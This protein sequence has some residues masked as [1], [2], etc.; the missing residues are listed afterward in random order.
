M[1]QIPRSHLF[2]NRSIQR[3]ADLVAK[4][5]D[6][7]AKHEQDLKILRNKLVLDPRDSGDYNIFICTSKTFFISRPTNTLCTSSTSNTSLISPSW[8]INYH[9]L[10]FQGNLWHHFHQQNGS[11]HNWISKKQI[12]RSNSFK[13]K[14]MQKRAGSGTDYYERT[15]IH[16]KKSR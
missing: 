7:M 15:A 3:I 9:Q 5:Y 8:N 12:P 13:S 6:E 2:K 4:E 14:S 11:Y 16:E 1:E 10:S